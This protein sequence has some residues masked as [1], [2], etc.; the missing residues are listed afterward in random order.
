[1]FKRTIFVVTLSCVP[2]FAEQAP[3]PT[4]LSKCQP[5]GQTIRGERI[6]GL[7]CGAINNVASS[8]YKPDMPSTNMKDTVIP[9]PGNVQTPETTPTKGET[10]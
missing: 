4:E 9:K 2:A 5:I 7:D 8:E 10:R 6:Y 3:N 1:M